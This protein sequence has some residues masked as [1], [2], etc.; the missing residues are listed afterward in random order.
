MP[1]PGAGALDAYYQ[2]TPVSPYELALMRRIDE[3]HCGAP[4]RKDQNSEQDAQA[5]GASSRAPQCIYPDEAD[6]SPAL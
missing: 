1:V 3:L 2:A 4:V 6:G 5:G